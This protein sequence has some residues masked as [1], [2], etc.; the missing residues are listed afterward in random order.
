MLRGLQPRHHAFLVHSYDPSGPIWY[1]S[2]GLFK[3]LLSHFGIQIGLYLT[4]V[5]RAPVGN[6][7]QHLERDH[8]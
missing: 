3:D 4:S 6:D 7:V 1:I 8:H 2:V 5:S